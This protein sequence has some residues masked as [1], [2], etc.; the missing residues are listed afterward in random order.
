LPIA[1][2][3]ETNFYKIRREFCTQKKP[4]EYELE[5]RNLSRYRDGLNS[6]ED[7]T[8]AKK[9]LCMLVEMLAEMLAEVSAERQLF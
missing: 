4:R 1:D 2:N 3:N 8:N 5:Q 6:T 7:H 9:C